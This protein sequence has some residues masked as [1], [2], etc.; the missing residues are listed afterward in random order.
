[1]RILFITEVIVFKIAG[2]LKICYNITFNDL[3]NWMWRINF[4]DEEDTLFL[5]EDIFYD[6]KDTLFSMSSHYPLIVLPCL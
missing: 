1:M 4:T 2:C 3:Y 6:M 5:M